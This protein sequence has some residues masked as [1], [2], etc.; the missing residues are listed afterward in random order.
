[1]ELKEAIEKR[2]SIR[3]F[4]DETVD[5]ND[6][7]EM[8]R[9]AGL[10]PSVN[11][12]QPWKYIVI[13]N[14]QLMNKMADRVMGKI[15]VLPIRKSIAANNI[16]SQV[17]WFSTFFQNAPVV[18][19]LAVEPYESVLEKGVDL[20]KEEIN[21]SRNYPDLQS[22]GASIQ[23]LLLSAVDLGY[24]ACWLSGPMIA[25]EELE[26]LLEISSPWK[27]LTFVAVGK[28]KSAPHAKDKPNLADNLKI[29]D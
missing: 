7:R 11:N 16:K 27:L 18:I 25:H 29:F 24:G 4:S 2:T 13:T 14:K 26:E 17:T 19:A 5:I 9:L 10:A 22:A 1:M 15:R 8:I 21:K 23:N 28:P 6:I 12:F 3:N 20:S